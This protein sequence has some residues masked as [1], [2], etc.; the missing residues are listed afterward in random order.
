[1]KLTSEEKELLQQ[2]VSQRNPH[3]LY[4][5][6]SLDAHHLNKS[7]RLKLQMTLLEEMLERGLEGGNEPNKL[8]RAIDSIIGRLE[9]R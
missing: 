4:I 2:I 7:D 3:L 9:S 8:G 1:M 6:E 5:V